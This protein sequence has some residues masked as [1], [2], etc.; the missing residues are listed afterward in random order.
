MQF[1]AP[2]R[3]PPVGGI[4]MWHP[5]RS[6]SSAQAL[7][8]GSHGL[9][10]RGYPAGGRFRPL[11]RPRTR[12]AAFTAP[13]AKDPTR[14]LGGR[15]RIARPATTAGSGVAVHPLP[16]RGRH[17]VDCGPLCVAPA[18]PRRRPCDKCVCALVR[19]SRIA[20][21]R[22]GVCPPARSVPIASLRT[23]NTYPL[24][25]A[26]A[27]LAALRALDNLIML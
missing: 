9:R 8:L 18:Q 15:G 2:H 3:P 22:C 11:P 10:Q 13:G 25:I 23:D 5:L 19:C 12:R 16:P 6:S 24:H 1:P 21:V 14:W 4:R 7:H 27:A 20:G 17:R 26:C